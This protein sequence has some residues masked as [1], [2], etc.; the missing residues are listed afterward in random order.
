MVLEKFGPK[1]V[2][3]KGEDNTVADAL[4]RLNTTSNPLNNDCFSVETAEYLQ[5]DL[6]VNQFPVSY[7]ILQKYQQIDKSLLKKL[8]HDSN[9]TIEVFCGGGKTRHLICHNGKICVPTKLQIPLVEWYHVLLCHPGL[10]RTELTIKQHFTWTRLREDV[11]KVCTACPTCQKTKRHTIKYGH[12]PPKEAETVPFDTLCV[13]LIGPYSI[14]NKKDPNQPLTL[15]CATMID[16]ATG[17][18]EIVDIKTK[19]ADV[20]ANKIEQAWLTKYP[21]PT[22]V[23]T[24][25]GTEFLAEFT[26][27]VQDEYGIK[28]SPITTRN[29]QANSIVERVHQTIGNMLRTFSIQDLELDE[30]DPFA[31]I[32]SAVTFAI[33]ST[34]HTTNM[35]TPMQL[36]FGRDAVL[37]VLHEANWRYIKERKQQFINYNNKRENA[38]RKEHQYHVGD[39]VLIKN[40]TNIKY[41][42]D[43]YS[44]PFTV[45]EVRTNGTVRINRGVVTDTYNIRNVHPYHTPDVHT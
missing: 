19:R 20:I 30:E 29:P 31:G 45:V 37:N 9:Y 36:V 6:E 34:V 32:L 41:G 38:K 35:A 2:Y 5:T 26:Q 4:S 27:L 3:L 10:T 25:R 39:R 17:W 40:A 7:K 16:P 22:K 11:K 13:D 14:P 15:W 18:F 44:G 42:T 21:W 43:A 12:L 33:R 1:I 8:E 24:D 28:H 23:V